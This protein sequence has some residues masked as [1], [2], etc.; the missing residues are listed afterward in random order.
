MKTSRGTHPDGGL[1]FKIK[2][3]KRKSLDDFPFQIMTS[4]FFI[5][6]YKVAIAS[7]NFCLIGLRL[8]AKRVLNN[9]APLGKENRRNAGCLT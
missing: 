4:L 9:D 2:L 1:F 7:C 8:A 3:D 6:S 5:C